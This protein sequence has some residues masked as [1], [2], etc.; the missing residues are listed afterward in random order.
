[1]QEEQKNRERKG[2][3]EIL[4]SINFSTNYFHMGIGDDKYIFGVVTPKGEDNTLSK[5][6]EYNTL[7]K[8][9]QDIDWKIKVSL[10]KAIEYAFLDSVYENFN[11][12][13][14]G[15]YEEKMAYYYIEN[16]LYRTST[17]WDI[18]AQFYR[19]FYRIPV[20]ANKVYYNKIFNPNSPNSTT[21]RNDADRIY[22]YLNEEE[23]DD[24]IS[25][26][27]HKYVN[28][29][30]NKM[31]HRNS[32]SVSTASNFDMNI[33]MPPVFILKRVVDDYKKAEGFLT[34]IIG[35]VKDSFEGE[36]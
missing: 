26:G 13:A 11:M 16:A 30:R 17:A 4:S 10:N 20:E 25:K 3:I 27:T 34:E 9:L 24:D 5:I 2:L 21:F 28:E 29:V 19:I 32:P 35:R 12:L 15:S 31:T 36:G 18:L 22:R 1:M 33:K 7:Y 23:V 8:T 14:E 6:S